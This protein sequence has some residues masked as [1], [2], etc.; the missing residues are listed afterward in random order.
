MDVLTLILLGIAA[1]IVY[2]LFEK[3]KRKS[4][5]HIIWRGREK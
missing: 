3:P 4:Y 2:K 1:Y 5:K